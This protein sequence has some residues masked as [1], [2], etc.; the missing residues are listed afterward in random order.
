MT[1]KSN[2]DRIV[3]QIGVLAVHPRV[4]HGDQDVWVSCR[5]LPCL[6]SAD[7]RTWCRTRLACIVQVPLH[8]EVLIVWED[9]GA[10]ERQ[11]YKAI[12]QLERLQRLRS[13]DSVPAPVEVDVDV[14]TGQND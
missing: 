14:N 3:D 13:G 4:N 10:I 5:D 11:V 7:I 1:R 2:R 12:N 8:G 6:W 9:A